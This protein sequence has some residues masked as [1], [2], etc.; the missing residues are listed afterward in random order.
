MEKPGCFWYVTCFT[1]HTVACSAQ[2]VRDFGHKF[3]ICIIVVTLK[4]SL[5]R[6]ILNFHENFFVPEPK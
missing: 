1:A 5:S 4:L 6:T 3:I 2:S